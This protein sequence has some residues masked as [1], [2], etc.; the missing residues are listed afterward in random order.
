MK[1]K[2]C[3]CACMAAALQSPV[4]IAV[5]IPKL[6]ISWIASLTP[7]RQASERPNDPAN[8]VPQNT[9]PTVCPCFVSSSSELGA[10][11]NSD[12]TL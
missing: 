9:Y 1:V 2:T 4:S 12:R 5:L 10:E 6:L 8:V 7:E 3:C 11:E